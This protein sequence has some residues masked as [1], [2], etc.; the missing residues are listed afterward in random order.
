MNITSFLGLISN[1]LYIVLNDLWGM[2]YLTC[3]F[4]KK[5]PKLQHTSSQI[6]GS[7]PKAISGY[8]SRFQ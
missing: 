4:L 2:S 7:D 1:L 5:K 8:A 6:P 3:F